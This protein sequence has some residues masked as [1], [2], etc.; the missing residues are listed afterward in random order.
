[1]LLKE[2]L[3]RPTIYDLKFLTFGTNTTK[4]MFLKNCGC[5]ATVLLEMNYM[6]VCHLDLDQIGKIQVNCYTVG[7]LFHC[8]L[9]VMTIGIPIRKCEKPNFLLL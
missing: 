6:F 2:S 5:T 7:S 9:F 4:F 3:G 1:M 8:F